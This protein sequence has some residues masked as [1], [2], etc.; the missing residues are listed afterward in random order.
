MGSPRAM[1]LH[2]SYYHYRPPR[3][4][5]RWRRVC[6]PGHCWGR[7]RPWLGSS[8]RAGPLSAWYHSFLSCPVE[9]SAWVLWSGGFQ[10]AVSGAN[11]RTHNAPRGAEVL[12]RL[13][14]RLAELIGACLGRSVRLPSITPMSLLK[15][16]TSRIAI[17][18][19]CL[20]AWFGA[21]NHC[22]LAAFEDL[23]KSSAG[24]TQSCSHCPSEGKGK[25]VPVEMNAC[26][27]GLKVTSQSPNP[28]QFSN[29]LVSLLVSTAAL[30]SAPQYGPTAITGTAAGPPGHS[31]AETVLH[32]SLLAHAPPLLV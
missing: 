29:Q 12:D 18:V 5:V 9:P 17:T 30:T 7:R 22:A 6:L 19:A 21:S 26:C 16:R 20:L 27:K 2:D 13:E 10:I 23:V 4:F 15:S 24:A 28:V 31:F 14:R 1:H 32:R 8:D 3:P 25:S 11:R